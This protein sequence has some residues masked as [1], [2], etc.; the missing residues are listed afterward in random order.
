MADPELRER[1]KRDVDGMNDMLRAT[2]GFFEGM[3]DDEASEPVD[4]MK[5]LGDICVEFA[6]MGEDVTLAGSAA[7]P[8]DARPSALKRCI[9]NL[10]SNA[11]KYGG[12][13]R[14]AVSDGDELVLRVSDSGPGIP[15][16]LLDKV[17]E[18]FHRLEDSRHP[19]TG[20]TGLGLSIARDIA[21][22]HGGSLVLESPAA[23]GLVAIVTLPRR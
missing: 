3:G 4:I 7:R 9:T 13:A 12:N 17:F 20:G 23:G 10:V 16:A 21:Q 2:L 19:D 15:E 18:P 5:L 14:I 8:F 22:A 11:V 1:F 6:E